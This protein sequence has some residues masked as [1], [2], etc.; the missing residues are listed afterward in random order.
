MKSKR[1]LLKEK[2]T[3]E[4]ITATE[5]NDS[6]TLKTSTVSLEE[7][8][9]KEF[10]KFMG[11]GTGLNMSLVFNTFMK[12]YIENPDLRKKVSQKIIGGSL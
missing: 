11:K 5:K 10:Q 6:G 2:K 1:E 12:M 9:K 3:D 7:D 8:V 4:I